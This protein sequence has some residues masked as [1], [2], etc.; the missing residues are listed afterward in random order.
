M[1]ATSTHDSKRGEDVRAR[2]S[3][4]SEIPEEWR[5]R[6]TKWSQINRKKHLRVDGAY[7]PDP[8]E[9]YFL[10]QTLVGTWPF[11]VAGDA[12]YR[13]FVERIK[14]YMLKALRE[15]KI[16]TSWINPRAAYEEAF[17]R[18]V[19]AIMSRR[20]ANEFLD[21]FERFHKKIAFCGMCNS[22]SQTLLKILSPGVPDF[23]Q[24]TEIWNFTLVDPDNRRP[25]DYD[26]RREM[27]HDL[28]RWEKEGTL[29]EIAGELLHTW[30]DG[31][32]KMYVTARALNFRK[33]Q[34]RLINRAAYAPLEADGVRANNVCAF[35]RH[36][37][38]TVFIVVVPRFI[39]GLLEE[40]ERPVLKQ[41]VWDGS[42]LCLPSPDAVA[43]ENIFTGEIVRSVISRKGVAISLT[44]VFRTFPVA[45]LTGLDREK[46]AGA[47]GGG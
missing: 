40:G 45:L 17:S 29:K 46:G 44:D 15:A 34:S 12:E 20:T 18:F 2:I 11:G 23:Y 6:L 21:D 5:R 33:A 7:A 28:R 32:I 8:N 24:G 3:V 9:E 35:A 47:D 19:D 43:F 37:G 41:G 13:D 42:F 31:R 27:L 25:V 22:L 4:L 39:M 38:G 1:I 16:T 14:E 10:Y 36:G 30:K 26:R